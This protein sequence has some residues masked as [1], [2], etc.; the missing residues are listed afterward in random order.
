[1]SNSTLKVVNKSIA[2]IDGWEKVTGKAR[3]AGD[4]EFFNM[5]YGK[6]LR[7]PFPHARISKID[8]KRAEKVPGVIAV[9]TRDDFGDI[10]P[11]FGPALKDRPILAIDKVKHMG[12]PVA[13][14]AAVDE[15]TAEEALEL[16]EVDYEELPVVGDIDEAI[17]PNATIVHEDL[18]L[19]GQ[20]ADLSS[21]QRE[22]KT[23][24]AHHFSYGRGDVDKG[25]EQADHVFEHTFTT[26]P[27]HHSNLEPHVAIAQWEGD[28][29]TI[30]TPC[31]NPFAARGELASVFRIPLSKVRLIVPY[32]GGGNGCK[33][34]AKIEPLVAA[35]ARKAGRPVKVAL[36]MEEA[37]Q[38][39]TKHATKFRL[40]TGVNKDGKITARECEIYWD[41]GAYSD[42]GI[43][44]TRKSGYTSPGPYRIANLKVNSYSVY[45][46]KVPAGA[47]RGFGVPQ[48]YVEAHKWA[49]LAAAAG[50]AIAL[51]L[52]DFITEK[53]T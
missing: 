20:F 11:Y 15:A 16:I 34:Y 26:Q 24:I 17:K 19:S 5:A 32:I 44:V 9:L 22:E 29:L 2:R 23:N 42:I 39:N 53:M 6:V 38:T 18:R 43:R 51:E 1:M 50:N 28:E 46:N 48:D 35:L 40:K 4:L 41:T 33:T 45:T 7:S 37:F 49:N 21:M 31:Q 27:I 14:V 12:D 25:F 30:W 8:T 3:Y 52:R 36:S 13:A 10:D 47:L